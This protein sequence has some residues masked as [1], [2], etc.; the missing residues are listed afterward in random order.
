MI[1]GIF[2]ETELEYSFWFS[3]YSNIFHETVLS[4]QEES[5]DSTNK[6]GMLKKDIIRVDNEI[7][8]EIYKIYNISKSEILTIEHNQVKIFN[9]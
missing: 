6:Y 2:T 8:N 7:N 4:L 5:E 9:P 1:Y 3:R